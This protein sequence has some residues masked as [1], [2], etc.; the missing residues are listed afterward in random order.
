MARRTNR[1][2]IEQRPHLCILLPSIEPCCELIVDDG[3]EFRW[4]RL[5]PSAL[6]DAA[7]VTFLKFRIPFKQIDKRALFSNIL[8]T[9][10]FSLDFNFYFL[11]LL[12]LLLL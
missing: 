10:S 5:A 8:L 11:L 3:A 6:F 12:P 7:T 9:V 2:N 1:E 4:P